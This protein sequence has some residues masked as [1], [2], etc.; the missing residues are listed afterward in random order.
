MTRLVVTAGS[1][2]DRWNRAIW[3]VA[4]V[5]AFLVPSPAGYWP[6]ASIFLW[7]L[8]G[9]PSGPAEPFASLLGGATLLGLYA[10]ALAAVLRGLLFLLHRLRASKKP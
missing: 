9:D 2:P 6:A 10:C 7:G 8:V 3:L 1:K 5:L 4:V